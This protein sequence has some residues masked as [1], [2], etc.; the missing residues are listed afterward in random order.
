MEKEER[1]NVHKV[2]QK[3]ANW[4]GHILCKKR[5]LKHVREG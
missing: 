1:N 2:K 5:L 3:K 4:I